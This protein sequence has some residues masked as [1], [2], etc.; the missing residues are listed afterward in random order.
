VRSRA[1]RLL[2]HAS[3]LSFEHPVT[4]QV[5]AFTSPAPF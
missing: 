1:P 4:G 3:E 2:L 5:L